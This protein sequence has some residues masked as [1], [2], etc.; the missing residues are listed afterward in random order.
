MKWIVAALI[1]LTCLVIATWAVAGDSQAKLKPTSMLAEIQAVMDSTRRA[2]QAIIDEL[3]TDQSPELTRRRGELKRASRM[4]I[5]QIQLNYARGEGRTELAS[6]ILTSIEELQRPLA[7]G[8]P[9]PRGRIS[10][11]S[12]ANNAEKPAGGSGR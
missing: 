11:T 4:R 9:R 5:L 2:E 6:R 10:T 8:G 1:V 7:P 12:V 3:G